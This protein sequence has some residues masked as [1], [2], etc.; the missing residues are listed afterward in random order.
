MLRERGKV[1]FFSALGK[2]QHE[3]N[4]IEFVTTQRKWNTDGTDRTD[5]HRFF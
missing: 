1:M 2:R 5:L 4:Q 3:F